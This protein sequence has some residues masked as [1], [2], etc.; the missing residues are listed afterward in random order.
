M[1]ETMNGPRDLL[2]HELGDI[3]FAERL[4]LKEL[5]R[6]AGETND[7]ELKKGFDRH[8]RETE[9]QVRNLE[10]AFKQLGEPVKAERCPGIEGIKAEH[11]QFV[12]EEAPSQDLLDSFLTGAS[13]R[14]E[15]YEIAAYSGAITLARALGE[16]Q[17]VDLLERNLKQ[18]KETLRQVEKIGRRLAREG[19]K[20]QRASANGGTSRSRSKSGSSSSRSRGRKTTS[21][22]KTGSRRKS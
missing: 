22:R 7:A 10:K 19:A 9:Q 21:S 13:A 1:P 2:I 15:H 16:R 3:M 5:P 6:M 20:Q 8:A 12:Q 14:V 17:V 18:E 4:L 11:E